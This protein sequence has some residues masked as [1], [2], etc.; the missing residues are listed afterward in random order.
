MGIFLTDFQRLSASAQWDSL[1]ALYAD[2]PDF[3]FLES[4]EIQYRDVAAIREA[5]RSVSPGTRIET[6]YEDVVVLPLAPGVATVS[7]RFATRFVDAAG[8]GFA[9]AGAI[10]LV[11]RH[12]RTGWRI[13]AGHSSA[14][15]PRGG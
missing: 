3:R 10:S 2:S 1:G 12:D 15:V 6:R 5:L 13:V 9:F 11:V 8:G 4:G 14:P 7:G